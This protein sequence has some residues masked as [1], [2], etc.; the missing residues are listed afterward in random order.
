MKISMFQ[1]TLPQGERLY[2]YNSFTSKEIY[3][4][5]CDPSLFISKSLVDILEHRYNCLPYIEIEFVRKIDVSSVIFRFAL[6]K[7]VFLMIPLY[8][9]LSPHAL[10]AVAS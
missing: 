6:I 2:N 10:F 3:Y 5:F 8:V 1:S 9:F 7:L 4:R